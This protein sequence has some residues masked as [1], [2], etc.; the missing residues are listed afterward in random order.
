MSEIKL[1]LGDMQ[2]KKLRYLQDKGG[3]ISSSEIN[4]KVLMPD[5]NTAIIDTWGRVIWDTR[6]DGWLPI[7]SAPKDG[8]WILAINY[9]N[10]T[11]QH[12]VQYSPEREKFRWVTGSAP[13]D[14]IAGLTHWRHLPSPPSDK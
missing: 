3:E 4:I 9:K 6:S 1:S 11:R 8:A 7:E 10:A 13:M 12:V 2:T 5:G 14:F